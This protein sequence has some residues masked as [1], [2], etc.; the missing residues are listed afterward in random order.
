MRIQPRPVP[1]LLAIVVILALLAC[2]EYPGVARQLAGDS[3]IASSSLPPAG[4]PEVGSG[5][6]TGNQVVSGRTVQ[7][8]LKDFEI[9]PADVTVSAGEVTFT[10]VNGGRYTHDFRVE[11]QGLN[12]KSPRISAGRTGEW[13]I[14]L[15]PGVYRI[16]CPIS[17]HADRGMV[18]TLTVV[19]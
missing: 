2:G 16:S 1:C 18:G 3:T 9:V 10:L 12:E 14:T 5:T 8:E 17:N 15:A 7:L 13:A 6:A 4:G 19:P 11:G